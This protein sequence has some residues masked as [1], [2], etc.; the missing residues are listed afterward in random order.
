MALI[1]LQTAMP[2]ARDDKTDQILEYAALLAKAIPYVGGVLSG[3]LGFFISAEEVISWQDIEDYVDDAIDKALLEKDIR[4]TQT[5]L[6]AVRTLLSDYSEVPAGVREK[7][8]ESYYDDLHDLLHDME[9]LSIKT[10][11]NEGFPGSLSSDGLWH[12]APYAL[13]GT[14]GQMAV[15]HVAI[16]REMQAE[17]Y[18]IEEGRAR[19]LQDKLDNAIEGYL[20]ASWKLLPAAY[21][22]RMGELRLVRDKTDEDIQCNAGHCHTYTEYRFEWRDDW[23]NAHVNHHTSTTDASSKEEREAKALLNDWRREY[24]DAWLVLSQETATAIFDQVTAVLDTLLPVAGTAVR[25]A[26]SAERKRTGLVFGGLRCQVSVSADDTSA[27]LEVTAYAAETDKT[28]DVHCMSRQKNDDR[29]FWSWRIELSAEPKLRV[30]YGLWH[31]GTFDKTWKAESAW[32]A[33]TDPGRT[34]SKNGVNGKYEW[35]KM[36]ATWLEPE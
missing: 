8:P 1:D 19:Y 27:D 4:D 18:N 32:V 13:L 2:G 16:L 5:D 21:R 35:L 22:Q 17:L 12:R 20:A 15:L 10:L 25:D 9:L 24:H 6:D 26:E 23:A 3:V 33:W 31:D 29:E 7:A 14:V 30:I 11:G 36:S 34:A 28:L